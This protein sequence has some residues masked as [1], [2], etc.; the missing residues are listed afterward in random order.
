MIGIA[1]RHSVKIFKNS[2]T[3]RTEGSL[4]V[5]QWQICRGAVR[6][7]I[8]HGELDDNKQGS[9]GMEK[10]RTEIYYILENELSYP[11]IKFDRVYDALSNITI[12]KSKIDSIAHL[13][14][15]LFP[16]SWSFD[17]WVIAF[18]FA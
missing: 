17:A 5:L 4:N 12:I 8:V 7:I 3:E 9:W 6:H 11:C 18:G 10:P 14:H 15:S 16:E 1:H 13:Q 2:H